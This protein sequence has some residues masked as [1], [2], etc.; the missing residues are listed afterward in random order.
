MKWICQAHSEQWS[1][2]KWVRKRLQ[3]SHRVVD[4]AFIFVGQQSQQ[5]WQPTSVGQ[6]RN[7]LSHGRTNDR[8]VIG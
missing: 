2:Q 7:G 8:E 3:S 1:H 4:N 6:L 5:R